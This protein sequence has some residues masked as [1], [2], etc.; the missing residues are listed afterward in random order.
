MKKAILSF[1]FAG[2]AAFF[3]TSCDE[4]R[5][6]NPVFHTDPVLVLNEPANAANNVYDLQNAKTITFT[7][8]QPN[9]GI[10]VATT[11]QAELS[12]DGEA[13]EEFGES[14]P[15]PVV[16]IDAQ[17]LN[18]RIIE[19]NG[20]VCP[21][22]AVPVYVRLKSYLT[23]DRTLGQAVSNVIQINVLPYA[24]KVTVSMPASMH[25]V[26]SFAAS[27]EW[28]KFVPMA[29]PYSVEGMF[30]GVY[31]FADGDEFKVVEKDSW[32]N[33]KG[34]DAVILGDDYTKGIIGQG[35]GTNM[36]VNKAGWY[37]VVVKNKISGSD[38]SYT[39]TFSEAKVY[40]FGA[41][42]GGI[43]EWND[44]C[45][46]TAPADAA[47]EWVSPEFADAGEVRMAIDCG[48]DWWKTE[49]TLDGNNN[50]FYRNCDIPGNWESDLGADYSK[51]AVKGGHI[52]INFT[53]GTGHIEN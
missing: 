13:F 23:V 20:D 25:I 31:Y 5:D 22:D 46:F 41:A 49:F 15:T 28:A 26:G 29:V 27:E 47:G 33:D 4:D 52:Y 3:C 21:T 43:W 10:P 39:I 53:K 30:Y 36:K 9:N 7:T 37:T 1:I 51:K 11:Y 42:N 17:K 48:T 35:G 8:S 14:S 50:I 18:A 45:R 12:F 2:V 16:T 40:L 19:V 34:Y 32:G 44:A 38:V 6:S 24:P